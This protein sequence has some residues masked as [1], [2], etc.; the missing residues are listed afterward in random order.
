GN[1]TLNGSVLNDKSTLAAGNNLVINGQN[2]N[3]G[4]G[5]T[6][7][8]TVQNIAFAPTGTLSENITQQTGIEYVSFSG[9]RHWAFKDY[10]TWGTYQDSVQTGLGANQP[11]WITYNA[12]P[13]LAATMSA[14][15][16]VSITAQTINNTTVGANGQPVQAVIGLG[17]NSAGQAVGGSAAATVGNATGTGGSVGSIAV[18]NQPNQTN[19]GSLGLA[20]AHTVG[21]GATQAP[22]QAQGARPGTASA[23]KASTPTSPVAGGSTSLAPPQVVSTL[24]GPNATINL[25]QTGLYTVNAQP[26]SQFLVETNP[27]F[28]QYSKFISS[29]YMLQKLS[30]SPQQ[31]QQRLG[32]GFYEQQRVL[33]QITELTGR[34]YLADASDALDQYRDLMNNA[35]QVAQQFKLSVGVALTPDQMASLTQDIVWLVSANVDGHQ[36]LEP[37]VYLSAADAKNLAANGATIAGKNVILT[38]SGDITNNGNIAASQN[39]QLTAS[40]LLNSGNISAGNDLSVSAAQNILNGGTLKAGGNVSL[41][42]GG[43]VLSGVSVAQ[44]LGAIQVNGLSNTLSPVALSNLA[45]PGSISAGGSLS[46]NAGRDLTLDTAPVMAGNN[47]SL[48]AGRDLTTTATAISAGGS[49]QLL[50]GR[51]LDLLATG[52]TTHVGTQRNGT[53]SVTHTVSTLQAGGGLT[54]LAG[55]DV[56]SQGAQLTGSTVALGAGRDINL[57]AVTDTTTRSTDSFAHHTEVSTGQSDQQVRGTGISGSNGISLAAVHDLTVTAG[58]LNSANGNVTLSAGNNLN[59]NAAQEDHSS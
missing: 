24:V 29:D 50:A 39:A 44:S 6:S 18:G 25:P 3:N 28:T 30:L 31:I 53:E 47:L 5:A 21:I 17:G 7:T 14:G 11:G 58:S 40:N 13:G 26:G 43:D 9:G 51:D 36:V 56:T 34:R 27:Q 15:N 19:G 4:G 38:A 2:G 12:G 35:V 33:D 48:A 57:Q 49:A 22:G 16:T 54:L 45:L 32:D 42:A 23:P 20:S 10:E 37:V 46:I 41:V 8:Y 59:L 55:R 52:T 1:I